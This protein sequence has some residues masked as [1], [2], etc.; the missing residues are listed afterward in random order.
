MTERLH[1]V[2]RRV[3]AVWYVWHWEAFRTNPQGHAMDRTHRFF[4][5]QP[6]ARGQ[7]AHDQ[8]RRRHLD[9]GTL[10]GAGNVGL[11][12]KADSVTLFDVFGYGGK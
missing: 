1:R 10:K 12:T 8:G 5:A 9:R 3:A 11:W 4:D 2:V 7:Q 6:A